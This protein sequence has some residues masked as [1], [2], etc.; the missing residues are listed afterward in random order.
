[1]VRVGTRQVAV[2]S[3]SLETPQEVLSI[4][5]HNNPFYREPCF[6]HL[7][8]RSQLAHPIQNNNFCPI[9]INAS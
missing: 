4:S 8:L 1:M 6:Y 9:Q 7:V 2:L 5:R 3:S